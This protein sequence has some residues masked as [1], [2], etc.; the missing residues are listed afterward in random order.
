MLSQEI[1]ETISLNPALWLRRRFVPVRG[2]PRCSILRHGVERAREA[3]SPTL[4]PSLLLLSNFSHD[5]LRNEERLSRLSTHERIL[6][7]LVARH[8]PVEAAVLGERYRD[9]LAER[10]L[11]AFAHRTL[12]DYLRGLC[13]RGYPAREHG[14]GTPGWIYRVRGEP[15]NVSMR[16]NRDV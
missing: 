14:P 6:L 10:S 8:E 15:E 2:H 12:G 1:P 4:D 13:E 3:D 7:D 5:H 9:A 11:P 16:P